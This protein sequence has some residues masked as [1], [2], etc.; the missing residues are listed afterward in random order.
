M[1]AQSYPP[2]QYHWRPF[3]VLITLIVAVLAAVF[4]FLSL[5]HSGN[6][7][8]STRLTSKLP[9]NGGPAAS[10]NSSSQHDRSKQKD[11]A[12][13][14][15]TN[16]AA[17]PQLT[18]NSTRMRSYSR[19]K[20]DLAASSPTSFAPIG[21]STSGV[22]SPIRPFMRSN[23]GSQS[24]TK[25]ENSRHPADQLDL[26]SGGVGMNVMDPDL[27][28]FP[29][30][31][32]SMGDSHVS[33][34]ATD[35]LNG[36][37]APLLF[38]LFPSA[39]AS[40]YGDRAGDMI[41]FN[42][43]AMMPLLTNGG[44]NDRG[45][46]NR[47]VGFGWGESNVDRSSDGR[48]GLPFVMVPNNQPVSSSQESGGSDSQRRG[49]SNQGGNGSNGVT[50]AWEPDSLTLLIAGAPPLALLIRTRAA[51]KTKQR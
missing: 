36:A 5:G 46:H 24:S 32:G 25:R 16:L 40:D 42:P 41:G 39:A 51:R 50:V 1:N 30:V 35:S 38:E 3:D 21:P 43:Y 20:T 29:R 31:A 2:K 33:E 44:G 22:G 17:P 12:P 27:L 19:P 15:A 9:T 34:Q 23:I 48:D 10:P 26:A 28:D 14:P 4:V 47:V 11:A 45:A 6:R 18:E 13:R 8:D 37:P 7:D 49:P